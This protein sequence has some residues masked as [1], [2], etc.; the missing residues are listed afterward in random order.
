[1]LRIVVGV[2]GVLGGVGIELQAVLGQLAQ[3]FGAGTVGQQHAG[4]GVGQHLADAAGG[5]V[6][7]DGQIAA[8]GLLHGEPGD[9]LVRRTRSV[10]RDDLAG[11]DAALQQP[12]RQPV[13]AAVERVVRE[14]LAAAYHRDPVRRQPRLLLDAA[15][16]ALRGQWCR[17]VVPCGR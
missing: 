17:G 4:L 5:V 3:A 15:V 12:V 13:G 6:G 2:L 7:I 11:A 14:P 10:E 16:G 9:E 8:A 1:M